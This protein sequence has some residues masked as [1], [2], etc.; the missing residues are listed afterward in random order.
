MNSLAKYKTNVLAII[1]ILSFYFAG[2]GAA[3]QISKIIPIFQFLQNKYDISLGTLTLFTTTIGISSI[4]LGGISG[5]LFSY[6]GIKKIMFYA[7]VL[8]LLIG[9]ILPYVENLTLLFVFRVLEGLGHI[10]IVTVAPALIMSITSDK[11]KP[12]ILGL[13][14]TFFGVAFAISTGIY[15]IDY[16]QNNIDV[17]MQIHVIYFI[18]SILILLL[19]KFDLIDVAKPKLKN[20]FKEIIKSSKISFN[21]PTLLALSFFFHAGMYTCLLIFSG[22]ILSRTESFSNEDILN[23]NAIFP[24]LALGATFIS[25]S[26]LKIISAYHMIFIAAIIFIMGIILLI[27]S[28]NELI[29]IPI[30]VCF[31]A[32]GI[33][34]SAIFAR[35]G[36]LSKTTDEISNLNGLFAQ[37]G[38]LGNIILP[39][40]FTLFILEFFY[41]AYLLLATAMLALAFCQLFTRRK[42][43]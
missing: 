19:F 23:Y 9:V 11:W 5:K 14:G 39:Y 6:I 16:L 17:Y 2:V 29:I 13:W 38:N 35:I 10:G 32:M 1:C 22:L 26:F 25:S 24:L 40:I 7:S 41:F 30:I 18:P 27:F 8:S 34:Q 42:I 4:I 12:A 37:F 33:M 15:K 28:N 21:A 43:Q 20:I 31:I 3:S 36:D